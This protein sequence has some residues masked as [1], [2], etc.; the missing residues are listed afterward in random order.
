MTSRIAIRAEFVNPGRGNIIA[1]LLL[2]LIM[3]T[4]C[5][6]SAESQSTATTV[7]TERPESDLAIVQ[8]IAVSGDPGNYTFAVTISS[9]DLGCDR[10]VDWWEVIDLDGRLIYRR[11]LLHSHVNEQPFTRTGGP[12]EI[13]VD[14][15]V[16]VRAHFHP[17]G[18]TDGALRGSVSEGFEKIEMDPGFAEGL[19]TQAPLPNGCDF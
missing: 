9:Q 10:Y 15:K 17:E 2:A 5:R 11:V 3:L 19:E 4:G 14:E 12:V 7:A 16:I 13:V 1:L 18:Y 6:S 8:F